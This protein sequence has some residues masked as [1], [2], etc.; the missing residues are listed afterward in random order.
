MLQLR[1]RD[2]LIA[3]EADDFLTQRIAGPGPGLRAAKMLHARLEITK[4]QSIR[5]RVY[6]RRDP[7]LEA[8]EKRELVARSS[9]LR[10][11]QQRE[12]N[13]WRRRHEIRHDLLVTDHLQDVPHRLRKLVERY[14]RLVI[15]KPEIKSD[16]LSHVIGQPPLR[17]TGIVRGA[18]NRGAEPFLVELE[19]LT[20]TS[21][22]IGKLFLKRDHA[23]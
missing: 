7:F 4:M 13:W 19:E 3:D 17:V 6:H 5:A 2:Q 14:H 21:P 22:Q 18:S 20:G 15:T 1:R 12:G 9:F 23:I 10:D 11:R 8:V 16:A